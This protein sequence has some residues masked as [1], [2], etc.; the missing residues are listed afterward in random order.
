M[1]KL[2]VELYGIVIGHLVGEGDNFDFGISAD[3][4]ERFGLDSQVLSLAI[5]LVPHLPRNRQ[6]RRRN[7]FAELL[8]EGP[9]RIRLAAAAGVP[10]GDT[11]GMLRQYGRDVA[12]ALCIWDPTS[13]GE[14]LT[15]SCELLTE[16]GVADLL[17]NVATYP[18]GNKPVGGKT[19]LGGVQDKITLVHRA[20]EEQWARAL[21]GYPTTHIMKPMS[22]RHPSI[23]FDEEYGSRFARALGLASFA[24]EL[25]H[26]DGAP[27]LV[28]ER[29]DRAPGAVPQRIHQEDFNQ[30][31]GARGDQKYQRYGGVVSLRRVA[32]QLS[33]SG[34]SRGVRLLARLAVLSVAL[35][36][37]DL[38][39]K[40]ISLLHPADGTVT[41]APAYDV[42]PQAHLPSDGEMAMAID[43]EYRHAS[44]TQ[45]H[46]ARELSSWG[47][48]C[49]STLV[50][51]CLEEILD[52][53]E[54]ETPDERAYVHL[55]DTIR[56]FTTNLLAG[57]PVG[58]PEGD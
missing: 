39:A 2:V 48:R 37:L 52:V 47:V 44:L 42:V 32:S 40:N 27:A 21:D 17:R 14:P 25:R 55:Q 31:L 29:F 57:Y 8:P 23:I 10:V 50:V 34:D 16:M 5:P 20:A 11:L 54:S 15:P 49:A 43:G 22:I 7:F 24:T 18:L 28:I 4:L 51:E 38:H 3:A 33:G 35:G 6:A 58:R 13:P 26:F 45:D 12:G 36:N 19:S 30:V 56:S 41:L 9:M 46:L 53:A 1:T